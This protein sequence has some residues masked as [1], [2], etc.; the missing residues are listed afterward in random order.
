MSIL[1][2]PLGQSKTERPPY[3]V[4]VLTSFPYQRNNKVVGKNLRT[5]RYCS[6]IVS[7][8]SGRHTRSPQRK[9]WVNRPLLT[10]ARAASDIIEQQSIAALM[11]GSGDPFR[12]E[13]S[14]TAR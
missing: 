5:L 7:P 12:S 9:L 10:K 2:H 14:T 6:W 4:V 1:A 13:V 11:G 8:R 3:C